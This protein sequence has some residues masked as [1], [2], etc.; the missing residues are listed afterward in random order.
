MMDFS[1]FWDSLGGY[2]YILV[3]FGFFFV[4][5]LINVIYKS[6]IICSKDKDSFSDSGE[7]VSVIITANNRSEELKE[8]LE[9][10]LTQDYPDFEVIVVDE[11]SEDNTQEV[12]A[13]IQQ[14]YPNLKTTRIFPDTKFRSTKKL[15]I[16]IGI[17]AA[18]YD[19]LLFSETICRPSSRNWL[20]ETCLAFT[21]DT[22]VVLGYANYITGKGNVSIRR[23]FRFL[24]FLELQVL[25]R[26]GHAVWGDG[27]NM[28]YR[29]K[30]YIAERGFSKNSQSYMGYDNEMVKALSKYGKVKVVRK[31]EALVSINDI[32]KKTWR[33]DFTYYYQNK[34]NWPFMTLLKS[35]IDSFF[36]IA[37]C[38]LG[39]LL[40]FMGIL[41][42]YVIGCILL[43][44][45]I[46]FVVINIYLKI[47]KEKKLFLT[48]F[49]VSSI[50]FLYEWYYN[51]YAIFTNKK[52]R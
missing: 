33:E 17:L 10:F 14:R 27:R 48:S 46:D 26:S 6:S 20:K 22:A 7:G 45:L 15:A 9:Y 42:N 40:I 39:I 51:V 11:C 3:G 49:I 37:G 34:R 29:K 25:V 50:G 44:F 36:R 41:H 52:W 30:F 21:P 23:I 43:M 4:A 18:K 8:N 5:H 19:R 24:R 32:K 38:I 16:N 12:L 47:Q 28:G 31:E 13:D 2:A 35:N 1:Q